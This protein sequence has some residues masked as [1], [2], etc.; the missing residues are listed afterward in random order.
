MRE[1]KNRETILVEVMLYIFSCGLINQ[2]QLNESAV[3]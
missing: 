2:Y 3:S 1:F